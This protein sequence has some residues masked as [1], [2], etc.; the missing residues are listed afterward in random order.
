MTGAWRLRAWAVPL[1]AAAALTGCASAG[2]SPD[3]PPQP[4][5][6]PPSPTPAPS[7]SYPGERTVVN[8]PIDASRLLANTGVTLQW[9]D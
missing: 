3:P 2:A 6:A 8:S 4:T 9:I 5:P 7:P 1:L